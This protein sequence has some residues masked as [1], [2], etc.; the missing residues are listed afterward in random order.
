M[1]SW[2]WG[3]SRV[4]HNTLVAL[5]QHIKVV[6]LLGGL[7]EDTDA[8]MPAAMQRK[9]ADTWRRIATHIRGVEFNF[10][11]WT[12]CTP[13]RSTYPACRAVIA[14][15]QQGSEYDIAMTRAIQCAYYQ[16]ARNPSETA[17][18]IELAGEL[19]LNTQSFTQALHSTQTQAQLMQEIAQAR[20]LG[21]DSFPSLVL[22]QHGSYWPIPI[23][24]ND[25]Q[26]M[27]ELIAWL[28]QEDSQHDGY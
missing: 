10:D 22:E 16:Q 20:Q 23:D 9:I 12:V 17:T 7:A 6:R 15:R 2:C 28:Q 27:L 24:Y 3:F 4:W 25:S 26:P 19:G 21:V 18:L 11:F 5:P 14:A 13:R 1:C 8:V